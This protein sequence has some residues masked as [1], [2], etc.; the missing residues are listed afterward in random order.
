MIYSLYDSLQLVPWYKLLISK[1]KNNLN[2]QE[3]EKGLILA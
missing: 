2:D 3:I 1:T